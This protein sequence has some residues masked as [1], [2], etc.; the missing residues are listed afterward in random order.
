MHLGANLPPRGSLCRPFDSSWKK[1]DEAC[2]RYVTHERSLIS[3]LYML[4]V[5]DKTAA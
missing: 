2:V 4:E 3:D 5:E 1:K